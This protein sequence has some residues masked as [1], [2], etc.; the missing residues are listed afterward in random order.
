[1]IEFSWFRQHLHSLLPAL[2]PAQHPPACLIAYSGGLDSQ[3]LLHLCSRLELP[4]R[5]VHVHHGLQSQADAW[6]E[7]CAEV[8]RQLGIDFSVVHVNAATSNGDSP[9]DAARKVRYAALETELKTGECLLTA[10]HADDQAETFLL[11]LMRGAGNAGLAAMPEIKPFAAGWHCRPLLV[12]TRSVI[13][14]YARAEGLHWI[15]DPSNQNTDFD[16]NL[17]RQSILPRLQQRWPAVVRSIANSA[18][19]QQESLELNQALARIDL[20]ATLTQDADVLSI[21]KCQRL[22]RARQLNLLRYW[23]RL[24]AGRPPSRNLLLELM[25]SLLSAA[26]DTSPL[27]HWGDH[28]LRRYQQKLYLLPVATA[29]YARLNLAWDGKASIRLG[30]DIVVRAVTPHSPGLDLRLREQKLSLRFRRSGERL[31]VQGKQHHQDLKKLMQA[32]GIPPWQR[33]RIPLLYVDDE[34]ACVCGYWLAEPFAA[35]RDTPGWLPVCDD[36]RHD[37]QQA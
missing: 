13:L 14:E 18:Q 20:A 33:A 11:Q 2:D 31:Q 9:E 27:V 29:D 34:L 19:F 16:R 10:H 23:L 21:A 32:A 4:V 24:R 26:P 17:L 22:S 5:A 25:D 12:Y 28:E 30:D 7:H 36:L 3:V 8:C 37:I 15:E 35:P 1:M 6:V